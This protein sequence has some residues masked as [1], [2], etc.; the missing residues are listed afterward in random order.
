MLIQKFI[1]LKEYYT[2]IQN[3]QK[4][5]TRIKMGYANEV[6]GGGFFGE[7]E[8]S[9]LFFLKKKKMRFLFF[10]HACLSLSFNLCKSGLFS[11]E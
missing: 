9:F 6:L 8:L 7:R 1:F 3:A 5:H 2:F 11:S 10:L 4:A